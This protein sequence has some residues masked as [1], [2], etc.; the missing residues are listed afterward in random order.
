MLSGAILVSSSTMFFYSMKPLDDPWD[1][2][3]QSIQIWDNTTLNGLLWT[4]TELNKI[5]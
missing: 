1:S 2:C 3:T 4:D 5:K